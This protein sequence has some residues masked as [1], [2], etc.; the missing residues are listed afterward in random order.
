MAHALDIRS[1]LIPSTF[2]QGIER[3][4]AR[5]LT[6][7]DARQANRLYRRLF[8]EE[9]TFGRLALVGED[10]LRDALKLEHLEAESLVRLREVAQLLA[11]VS[12]E[13]RQCSSCQE[14]MLA[15]VGG[16]TWEFEEGNQCP[17]CHV[18]VVV[19]PPICLRKIAWTTG[20]LTDPQAGKD[21]S[22]VP[23][24]TIPLTDEG[25]RRWADARVHPE[26]ERQL[27]ELSASL[28]VLLAYLFHGPGHVRCLRS[29]DEVPE[30]LC[31][32]QDYGFADLAAI[33][34]LVLQSVA[35]GVQREQWNGREHTL[36]AALLRR[37]QPN[38]PTWTLNGVE[39]LVEGRVGRG[40]KSQVFRAHRLY[41]PPLSVIIK[42]ADDPLAPERFAREA[43]MLERLG[44][45]TTSEATSVYRRRIRR[46]ADRGELLRGDTGE[47]VQALVFVA[48][49]GYDWNLAEALTEYPEGLPSHAV[50]W[51]GRRMFE[52]IAWMHQLGVV[53]GAIVPEHV[54]LHP[55]M[56]YATIID[57]SYAASAGQP[58]DLH[59]TH[60]KAFYPKEIL[61]GEEATRAHDVTMAARCLL[62]ALTGEETRSGVLERLERDPFSDYLRSLAGYDTLPSV[63]NTYN[64]VFLPYRQ[65]VQAAHGKPRYIPFHLP[66]RHS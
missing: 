32:P 10:E 49:P 37:E 30:F 65:A 5:L 28:Y 36:R 21:V 66:A 18:G 63:S 33:R 45:D 4:L 48:K 14:L 59:V 58:I 25:I 60:R 54:L 61:D 56:H 23:G 19:L 17:V 34:A 31:K 11:K 6:S 9:L 2:T 43:R 62:W 39:Y 1:V 27:T 16:R 52:E 8:G 41:N 15:N 38:A 50:A 64:D 12:P 24:A 35:F 46:V 55:F 29:F 51:I 26:L 42:L 3:L 7:A 40:E 13:T 47:S 22:T 57:H 53:H 44:A 20:E